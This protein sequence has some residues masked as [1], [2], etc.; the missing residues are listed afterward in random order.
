MGKPYIN[1]D[2]LHIISDGT[3]S[4]LKVTTPGGE[5]LTCVISVGIDT[6]DTD[7][8]MIQATIVCEV[9]LG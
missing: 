1:K 7:T 8:D 9:R 5:E 4:G 2:A 3:A 6:I